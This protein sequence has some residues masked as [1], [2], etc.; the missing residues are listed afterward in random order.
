MSPVLVWISWALLVLGLA[1]AVRLARS[2]AREGSV[3]E[4]LMAAFFAGGCLG[5]ALLLLR[6]TLGLGPEVGAWLRSPLAGW[7][8]ET[9]LAPDGVLAAWFQREAIARLLAEH[10]SGRYDHG[11]RLWALLCLALWARNSRMV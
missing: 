11:K 9:L 8:R 6:P 7:T 1:L 2:A 10:D 5:Y 3:P 4:G